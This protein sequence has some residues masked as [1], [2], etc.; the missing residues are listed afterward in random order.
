M[1]PTFKQLKYLRT[2]A[3]QGSFRRAA[4]YLNVSQPTLTVQ[5][6][7]LEE[8]FGRVLLER[9]RQGA[10]LTPIGRSLMPHI[11]AIEREVFSLL[12]LAQE[13]ENSLAGTYRLGVPPTVGPYFLPEVIPIIHKTFPGLKIFIRE[14]EPRDLELGLLHG[15]YDFIMTS[16]P[17]EIPNLMTA[18]LYKEP[19]YLVCAIDHPFASREFVMPRELNGQNLLAIE[20]KHRLFDL[21][22]TIATEY[23]AKLLRDYEGTSLDTLKHMISTGLGIAFLPSLYVRLEIEARKDVLS[24]PFKG[25]QFSRE[26]IL[27][28]RRGSPQAEFYQ[29]IARLM[30]NQCQRHLSD[31]VDVTSPS[32]Q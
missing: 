22:Q 27:A 24:I 29:Q 2:V 3:E 30:R 13:A 12:Q 1:E 9:S 4:D 11:L 6:S 16:Q 21:M 10:K 7:V 31:F 18:S 15:E 23:G 19:L 28:W 17:M 32:P 8:K 14:K 26:I 5:I 20:E 25:E